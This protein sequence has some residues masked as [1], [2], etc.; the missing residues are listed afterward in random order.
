MN[1]EHV[2]TYTVAHPF[3]ECQVSC[4]LRFDVGIHCIKDMLNVYS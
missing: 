2:Q 3:I 1:T 4:I